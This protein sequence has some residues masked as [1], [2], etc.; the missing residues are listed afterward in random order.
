LHGST[1]VTPNGK[2]VLFGDGVGCVG[3]TTTALWA[4]DKWVVDEFSLYND[5]TGKV[6]GNKNMPI[7]MKSSA[8]IYAPKQFDTNEPAI[9]LMPSDFGLDIVPT[10]TLDAIVSPHFV[11]GVS[12][13]VEE[14]DTVK[15]MKKL[16]ILVNA[17]RLKFSQD[18]LDRGDGKKIST[19][20]IELLDYVFGYTIPKSLLAIPYYDAYL[21]Q[22]KDIINLIKNI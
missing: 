13:I 22:S 8:L 3:K 4:A 2:T 11:S 15:K 21:D 17:H 16:A 10:A 20:E 5:L 6:Y 19:E 1:V 18:G 12:R 14:V 7:M 9:H